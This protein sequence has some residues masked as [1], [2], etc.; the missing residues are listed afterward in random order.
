M[1]DTLGLPHVL[2]HSFFFIMI[3]RQAPW[4]IDP[5]LAAASGGTFFSMA[6]RQPDLCVQV[7]DPAGAFRL[8]KDFAAKLLPKLVCRFVHRDPSEAG[9]W[10][11]SLIADQRQTVAFVSTLLKITQ[12][13]RTRSV[14]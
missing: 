14:E 3:A 13:M 7:P 1:K 10:P 8:I 11:A 2:E 6:L 12:C 9:K 5:S 4:Q